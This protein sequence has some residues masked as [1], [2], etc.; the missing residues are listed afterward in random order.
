MSAIANANN[1]TRTYNTQNQ[2]TYNTTQNDTGNKTSNVNT[3]GE[4]AEHVIGKMPGVSYSRL[5][6]EFRETFLN[7][8]A[9]ILDDLRVCFFGLWD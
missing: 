7:I 5:L 4:Y 2:R 8:D 9:M 1:N 3:L 6:K